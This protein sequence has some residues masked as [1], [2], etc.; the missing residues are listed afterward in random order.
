M[1]K[2]QESY[3]LGSRNQ[4]FTTKLNAFANGMYLTEQVIPEGY[5]KKMINYDI[6]ATGSHIKPRRGR[7]V[8]QTITPDFEPDLYNEQ[9]P[10]N[11]FELYR[12]PEIYGQINVYE[13]DWAG[14]YE[15]IPTG[16]RNVG[17]NRSH[18]GV[19]LDRGAYVG[20]FNYIDNNV[21]IMR[22]QYMN[23]H[24]I[25]DTASGSIPAMPIDRAAMIIANNE[26]YC[27]DY[28]EDD[29]RT[30]LNNYKLVKSEVGWNT[31]NYSFILNK[32]KL[33]RIP[34][35]VESKKFMKCPPIRKYVKESKL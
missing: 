29:G 21:S 3:R 8:V 2:T 4:R 14:G 31:Y 11:G 9:D 22:K 6:D 34:F 18:R 24:Y 15:K 25:Q 26:F 13:T 33:I 7:K 1:A 12:P 16:L 19:V 30:L 20:K 32:L 28:S 23:T 27:L 17:I 35:K 10:L 5:V